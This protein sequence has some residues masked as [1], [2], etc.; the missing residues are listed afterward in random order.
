MAA[1]RVDVVVTLTLDYLVSPG[2]RTLVDMAYR[3]IG[4]RNL[5]PMSP[6]AFSLSS[7]STTEVSGVTTSS[8]TTT[9]LTWVA[10][11][12]AGDGIRYEFLPGVAARDRNGDNAAEVSGTKISLVIEMTPAAR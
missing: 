6:G 8:K 5:H 9:T 4:E 2:D 1:S 3:R 12:L 11:S 10:P 7:P